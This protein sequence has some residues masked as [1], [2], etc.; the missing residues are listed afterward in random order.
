MVGSEPRVIRL[1]GRATAHGLVCA[2]G[3]RALH[4]R[5]LCGRRTNC[6]EARLTR[7][8]W[9]CREVSALIETR[10]RRSR[11]WR[12]RVI[13]HSAESLSSFPLERAAG[14]LLV[15]ANASD[16]QLHKWGPLGEAARR[17]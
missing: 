7:Q 4:A 11:K 15:Y 2:S 3:R 16:R 14:L 12:Y 8:S 6:V 17:A 1:Q 10:Y 9:L 13:E 5:T